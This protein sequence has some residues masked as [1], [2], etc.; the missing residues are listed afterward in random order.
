MKRADLLKRWTA[1]AAACSLCLL[2]FSSC[3]ERVSHTAGAEGSV[4]S[5]VASQASSS[6]SSSV[7]SIKQEDSSRASSSRRTSSRT[8]SNPRRESSQ[9]PVQEPP[10]K[11]DG[12]RV[13][14]PPADVHKDKKKVAYLTFDDGPSKQTPKVLKILKEKN[15]TATFFVVH[16]GNKD[17]QPYYRMIVEQGHQLAL[18]SYTHDYKKVYRTDQSFFDEFKRMQT[19]L[20]EQTGQ[21]VSD[22]RFPGGTSNTVTSKQRIKN[23]IGTLNQHGIRYYDWNVSS[24]DASCKK[25][26]KKKI[27]D[28]V[29]K[30]AVKLNEPVILMHDSANKDTT[31]QALPEIIDGLRKAGYRFDS[32]EHMKTPSQ[33]RKY[34]LDNQNAPGGMSSESSEPATSSKSSRPQKPQ[35]SSKPAKPSKPSQGSSDP[36]IESSLGAGEDSAISSRKER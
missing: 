32:V 11:V 10:P 19:F 26:S 13:Q 28:N 29:L 24:G 35:S 7:N 8:V 33:H 27:V 20:H 4:G 21:W 30:G 16:N 12:L 36:E 1:A 23:I 31:V 15:V 22:V 14:A 17:E 2:F 9:E 3:G 25:L 5:G 6:L 34:P 18:H